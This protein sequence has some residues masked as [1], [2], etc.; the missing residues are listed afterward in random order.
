MT[1]TPSCLRISR[2]ACLP[3]MYGM[4]RMINGPPALRHGSGRGHREID[5]RCQLQR[6]LAALGE[7]ETAARHH[8]ADAV[9][10]RG[11]DLSAVAGLEA[12]LDA[13]RV[14]GGARATEDRHGGHEPFRE[15]TLDL[16]AGGSV[17]AH[18]LEATLAEVLVAF[19]LF[20]D[21]V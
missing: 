15:P 14:A 19:L 10:I 2:N 11:G 6:Q 7:A 8:R 1:D 18:R 9:E 5:L 3:A 21:R 17:A 13:V 12:D 16:G 4:P 20:Q